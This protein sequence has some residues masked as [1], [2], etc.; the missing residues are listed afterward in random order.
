MLQPP[1]LLAPIREPMPPVSQPPK[2]KNSLRDWLD[3]RTGYRAAL[4]VLFGRE[5]PDGPKWSYTTASCLFWLTIVQVVT[6]FLLMTTYSPSLSTAWASVHFIEQSTAGSFLRGVHH[7]AAQAMIALFFVHIVRVVLTGAY[8][9]PRELVWVT[10]LLLV[11]LVLVWTVTGNPLPASQR[12][13]SQIDVEGNILESTPLI[14]RQL[15]AILIGGDRVGH[16]TLT[17]LYFL[18]V[19]FIPLLAG[20]LLAIHIWQIYRHGLSA[21]SSPAHS[22][23]RIPYW[24]YQSYRN[25]AAL[26]VVL[27]IVAFLSLTRGAPL[28]LPADPDVEHMPRPEWY[29]LSLF[30]L[31]RYF[32]G[33]WEFIATAVIPG[34]ALAVLAA[35]PLMDRACSR[36]KSFAL[37]AGLVAIGL[38]VWSWLT[39]A[40]VARDHRDN[41]YQASESRMAK[42]S[43][44]AR[45]LADHGIPVEGAGAIL[46]NDP[47]TQ[48]PRLFARHCAHCH[49]HADD[50]GQGILATEPSAP[51]LYGFAT[52][53]WISGLLDPEQI[54]GVH[55]FGRTKAADGEMVSSVRNLFDSA[56]DGDA[57]AALGSQLR[58]VALALAAES[59]R[60]DE[61]D[62]IEANPSSIAEGSRLM[63]G[64]LGCTD[65][66]RFHDKGEL[67]SAP[68]LTG[69]GSRRW[70]LGMIGN[71]EHEQFYSGRNDR[72]PAFLSDATDPGRNLLTEQELQLLVDWLRGDWI[73]T[74]PRLNVD[75]ARP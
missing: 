40:S 31:R 63:T 30:E 52:R 33:S 46:R 50:K 20:G 57:K 17:H 2:K 18:H 56:Q 37:R 66:H 24:P 27:G 69:Y 6:G 25:M 13:I 45:E 26:A 75:H 44:R 11:P 32:T 60:P 73:A 68:D 28:E 49:S 53:A 9:A 21:S 22:L 67:G 8:R 38:L 55:Y 74:K 29:F 5:L 19:A 64:T 39:L 12:G 43:D 61:Q 47:K 48:G 51:N 62:Q 72:M 23:L 71:P 70:L 42:L 4:R 15:R 35:L 7:Y 1:S 10:G 3:N 65:C 54:G 34:A 16:L 36:R 59:A 58:Q 41:E 14:G